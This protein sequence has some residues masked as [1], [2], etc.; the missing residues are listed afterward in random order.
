MT[1]EQSELS[2][3]RCC[4]KANCETRLLRFTE[5]KQRQRDFEVRALKELFEGKQR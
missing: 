1:E 5:M 2:Q 3:I 4:V